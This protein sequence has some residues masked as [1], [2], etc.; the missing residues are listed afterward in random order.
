V[1]R[2]PTPSRKDGVRLFLRHGPG[3]GLD[4]HDQDGREL[5]G[6]HHQDCRALIG[7]R[8][9]FE[10]RFQNI[11]LS[12][13]KILIELKN[14]GQHDENGRQLVCAYDVQG[15]DYHGADDGQGADDNGA[16]DRQGHFCVRLNPMFIYY[17]YVFN[18]YTQ[19]HTR[20]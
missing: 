12:I 6:R 14:L 3:H 5:F 4:Q 19:T 8:L 16:D 18:V 2:G 17:M 10:Y 20:R 11:A 9:Y 15:R 1:G 7:I 13:D